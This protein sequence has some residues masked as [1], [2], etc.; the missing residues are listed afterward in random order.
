[1]AEGTG[2]LGNDDTIPGGRSE[3]QPK[4][5]DYKFNEAT[6]NEEDE[7]PTETSLVDKL[8]PHKGADDSENKDVE[9]NAVLDHDRSP[10]R[11]AR[12]AIKNTNESSAY[13]SS[14]HGK[15][16]PVVTGRRPHKHDNVTEYEKTISARRS[17]V[18]HKASCGDK[19][20]NLNNLGA[21]ESANKDQIPVGASAMDYKGTSTQVQFQRESGLQVGEMKMLIIVTLISLCISIMHLSNKELNI[22]NEKINLRC[23]WKRVF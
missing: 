19:E 20:R 2:E 14:L 9:T 10:S 22:H 17:A 16:L 12:N 3:V 6:E 21:D 18:D 1:M 15:S 23:P 5:Y 11:V 4:P 8:S 13:R 7:T